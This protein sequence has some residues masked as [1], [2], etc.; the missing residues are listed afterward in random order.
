[1]RLPWREGKVF[2][3]YAKIMKNLKKHFT[4]GN[5]SIHITTNI[6]DDSFWINQQQMKKT[7]FHLEAV[8]EDIHKLL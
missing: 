5:K 3:Y 4:R 1:M 7:L 8:E 2:C 6:R